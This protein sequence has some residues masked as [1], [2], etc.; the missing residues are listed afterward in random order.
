MYIYVQESVE[1]RVGYALVQVCT[2]EEQI[3]RIQR[4]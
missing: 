1:Q 4:A 2:T 3:T